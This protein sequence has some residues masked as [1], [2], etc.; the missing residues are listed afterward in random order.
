MTKSLLIAALT[1]GVLGLFYDYRESEPGVTVADQVSASVEDPGQAARSACLSGITTAKQG[2]M[3][4]WRSERFAGRY[5]GA[6]YTASATVKDERARI[7][8]V[9]SAL[10]P[11]GSV[12]W[13]RLRVEVY[14]KRRQTAGIDRDGGYTYRVRP[15]AAD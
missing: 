15:S 11:D 6:R 10:G 5:K 8:S 9:G 12:E 3:E 7:E 14:R 13:Y 2:L 1:F 4:S